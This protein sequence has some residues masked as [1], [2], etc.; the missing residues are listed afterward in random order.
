MISIYQGGSCTTNFLPLDLNEENVRMLEK[1]TLNYQEFQAEIAFMAGQLKSVHDDM[2][3]VQIWDTLSQKYDGTLWTEKEDVQLKF[4][5]VA[6]ASGVAVMLDESK[7][8]AVYFDPLV[9]IKSRSPEDVSFPAWYTPNQGHYLGWAKYNAGDNNTALRLFEEAGEAGD[10]FSQYMCSM[11]YYLGQ[12][13]EKNVETALYWMSK[14][15][16]QEDREAQ[17]MLAWMHYWSGNKEKA[18]ECFQKLAR[19]NEYLGHIIGDTNAQIMCGYMT[20]NGIRT[21]RD[22]H[23]VIRWYTPA[24]DRGRIEARICLSR[25]YDE[26]HIPDLRKWKM[27]GIPYDPDIM[28]GQPL[29][30]VCYQNDSRGQWWI[31]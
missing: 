30:V 18:F 13:A 7:K 29:D 14:E 25:L 12:G 5:N 6:L 31:R 26:F 3:L 8:D 10:S 2:P 23:E 4:L 1:L 17:R 9:V 16:L 19:V 20:Q 24:A 27:A 15:E 11:M 21:N 22:L 28:Q